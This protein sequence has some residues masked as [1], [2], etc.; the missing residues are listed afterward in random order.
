[1]KIMFKQRL[2]VTNWVQW[3]FGKETASI[4]Q[5]LSVEQQQDTPKSISKQR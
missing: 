2:M 4:S 5:K 1:M 3:I